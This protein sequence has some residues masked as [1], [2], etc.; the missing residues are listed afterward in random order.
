LLVESRCFACGGKEIQ[1]RTFLRQERIS[2]AGGIRTDSE[3]MKAEE[4]VP[5]GEY[6]GATETKSAS[7]N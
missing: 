6:A 3:P 1:T 2:A 4:P 5:A 7:L